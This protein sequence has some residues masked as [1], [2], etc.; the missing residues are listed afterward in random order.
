MK[1]YQMWRTAASEKLKQTNRVAP[2]R[3]F[4][5]ETA[6]LAKLAKLPTSCWTSRAQQALVTARPEPV[7][8]CS[9]TGC[10]KPMRLRYRRHP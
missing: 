3:S 4:G 5:Q 1:L 8:A 2:N 6:E 10:I 7:R 9:G